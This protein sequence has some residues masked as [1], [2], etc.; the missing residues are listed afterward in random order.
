MVNVGSTKV[1]GTVLASH[2]QLVVSVLVA[3]EVVVD[4]IVVVA[5]VVEVLGT[6]DTSVSSPLH[7]KSLISDS[8]ICLPLAA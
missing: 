3:D 6:E 7:R 4:P 2:S 1:C 8:K 5:E